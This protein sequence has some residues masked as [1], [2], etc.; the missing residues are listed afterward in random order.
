M[1]Q[2]ELEWSPLIFKIAYAAQPFSG[3]VPFQ[4]RPKSMQQ[5]RC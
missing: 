1:F 5:P 3:T 4:L 2:E